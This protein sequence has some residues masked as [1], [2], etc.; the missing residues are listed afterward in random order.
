MRRLG[1]VIVDSP[2]EIGEHRLGVA[3][4]R[5]A[6]IVALERAHESLR[7]A[8]ALGAVTPASLSGASRVRG[9]STCSS[10]ITRSF[11]RTSDAF[12]GARSTL[13]AMVF[14]PHSTAP[15]ARSARRWLSRRM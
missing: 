9:R 2:T 11:A 4:I 5:I 10:D 8:V 13:R 6:A 12:V 3:E 15:R 7:Q 14:L 1:V